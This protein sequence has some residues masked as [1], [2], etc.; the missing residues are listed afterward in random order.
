MVERM[1]RRAS[2]RHTLA[3]PLRLCLPGAKGATHR[4]ESVDVSDGGVLLRTDLLLRIGLQLELQLHLPGENA[5]QPATEWQCGGRVVR[6]VPDGS[7]GHAK[8]AVNFEWVTMSR[9][10]PGVAAKKTWR[11]GASK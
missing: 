1:E 7:H 8:V 10:D 3:I 6:I 11:A 4:A 5:G 9:N 2:Y